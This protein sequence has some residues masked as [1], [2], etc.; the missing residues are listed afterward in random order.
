MKL[1]QEFL[2]NLKK[3]NPPILTYEA[4]VSLVSQIADFAGHPTHVV[5]EAMN[6]QPLS[7]RWLEGDSLD[8]VRPALLLQYAQSPYSHGGQGFILTFIN[9][10]IDNAKGRWEWAQDYSDELSPCV[11]YMAERYK[12]LA[13]AYGVQKTLQ[14]K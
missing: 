7:V 12:E 14:T 9:A 13:A 1:D 5:Y 4:I 8:K 6:G 3:L 10:G 2:D 11:I